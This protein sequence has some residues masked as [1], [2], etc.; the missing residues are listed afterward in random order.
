MTDFKILCCKPAFPSFVLFSTITKT[1]I[2]TI[3]P[4]LEITCIKQFTALTLYSIDTHFDASMTE[5]FENIVG[6]GEIAT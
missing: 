3:K 2:I 1:D 5:I 6:K 4:V